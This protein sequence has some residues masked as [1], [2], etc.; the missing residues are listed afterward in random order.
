VEAAVQEIL[1]GCDAAKWLT[2]S[3][4]E[5]PQEGVIPNRSWKNG[6]LF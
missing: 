5:T 3:I 1:Q 2:I 4:Q 6:I